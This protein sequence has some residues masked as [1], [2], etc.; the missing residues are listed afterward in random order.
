MKETEKRKRFFQI[1]LKLIQQKGF[2]AMTMRK[3][4]EAMNCDVSNI[5]NYVKSKDEILEQL[6]F[7]ISTKFHDG[8]TNIESSNDTPSKKLKAV[9]AL[10]IRLTIAHPNQV[11]LLVNEWRNL[12]ST[13]GHTKLQ[14]FI[15]FRT[16]YEQKL[17][18]IVANGIQAG[19]FSGDN[20]EFTTNC[21]L[22]SIRWLYSWYTPE[23]PAV[24]PVELE[25][26]MTG[27]ILN[28]V[29]VKHS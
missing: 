29:A 9:I 1:A 16:N 4:A 2:K 12:R 21:I 26:L 28:G 18:A 6:L 13:K 10:H 24:N 23:K 8:M 20:I 5:Y 7:E 15:E 25:Q 22:S 19:Q 3:L 17:K 14:D 11:A 27:F